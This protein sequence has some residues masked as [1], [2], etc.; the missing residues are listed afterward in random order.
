MWVTVRLWLLPVFEQAVFVWERVGRSQ[1]LSRF[2][3]FAEDCCAEVGEWDVAGSGDEAF[4]G[5][6]CEGGD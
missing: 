2:A 4:G 3:E 1:V 5:G 6:S